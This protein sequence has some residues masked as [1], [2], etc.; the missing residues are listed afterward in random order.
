MSPR[1]QGCRGALFSVGQFDGARRFHTS[2]F[3]ARA[4]S[5]ISGCVF[6]LEVVAAC[7]CKRILVENP[8][9]TIA[10]SSHPSSIGAA[11]W[12]LRSVS[13]LMSE[14]LHIACFF[15]SASWQM[16]AVN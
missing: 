1:R 10:L 8:T 14:Q 12:V 7:W 5:V 2:W 9:N 6:V 13:L 15:R 4:S 3:A 11:S 16:E